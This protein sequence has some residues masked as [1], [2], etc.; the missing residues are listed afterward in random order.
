M[1]VQ[2]RFKNYLEINRK[3]GVNVKDWTEALSKD[4]PIPGLGD[5]TDDDATK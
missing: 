3:L 2:G 5:Q 1:K 4:V